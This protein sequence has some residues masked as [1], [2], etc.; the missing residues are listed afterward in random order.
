MR[1]ALKITLLTFLC[2][3]CLL[4]ASAD[5]TAS[6]LEISNIFLYDQPV[7]GADQNPE[8]SLAANVQY[9]EKI[10][11][12]STAIDYTQESETLRFCTKQALAQD[13]FTALTWQVTNLTDKALYVSGNEFDT[14]FSGIEYD[15]CGGVNQFNYVLQPGE[16]LDARFHGWLWEHA[17]P[18]EGTLELNLR[19]Y[20]LTDGSL[21]SDGTAVEESGAPLLEEVA[22]CVPMDMKQGTVRS[23][24]SDGQ[25]LIYEMDGYTLKVTRADM[26]MLCMDIALERVYDTKEAAVADPGAG[27]SY[28]DYSLPAADGSLWIQRFYGTIPDAPEENADGTWSWHYSGKVYYMFSQPDTIILRSTHYSSAAGYDTANAEDAVLSFAPIE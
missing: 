24:L 6:V 15:L 9:R 13:D 11:A 4:S 26:G 12:L 28:W 27:D 18:G 8:V 19:V 10:A 7:E 5:G 22:F 1:N 21:A 14:D 20:E 17:E 23:A 25:P 3:M 2:L 16:T